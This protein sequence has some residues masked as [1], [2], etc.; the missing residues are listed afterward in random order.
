MQVTLRMKNFMLHFRLP[1]TVVVVA[2]AVVAVAASSAQAAN[3][4]H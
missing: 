3:V 2:A 4:A 1:A